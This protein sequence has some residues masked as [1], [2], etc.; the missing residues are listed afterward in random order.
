[1]CVSMFGYFEYLFYHGYRTLIDI[2]I[3]LSHKSLAYLFEGVLSLVQFE[4]HGCVYKPQY[5]LG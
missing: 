1:M 2:Y 3:F 5:H 4:M